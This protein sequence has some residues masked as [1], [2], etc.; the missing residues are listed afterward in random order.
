MNLNIPFTNYVYLFKIKCSVIPIRFYCSNHLDGRAGTVKIEED[1]TNEEG[2]RL[3]ESKPRVASL[4]VENGKYKHY[5]V[6][7]KEY[8]YSMVTMELFNFYTV[9]F[10]NLYTVNFSNSYFEVYCFFLL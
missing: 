5:Q 10:P 7:H 1:L 9:D 8:V 3:S 4:I 6:E 2:E